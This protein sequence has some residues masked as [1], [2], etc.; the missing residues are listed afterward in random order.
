MV[1]GVRRIVAGAAEAGDARLV[2]R[3]VQS[4]Y[5]GDV[6]RNAVEP[7]LAACDG[8]ARGGEDILAFEIG[9]RIVGL[10]D[11][12][13]EGC[14]GR[15]ETERIVY[16]DKKAA[17]IRRQRGRTSGS[18]VGVE[19]AGIAA[20]DLG[21]KHAGALRRIGARGR[22]VGRCAPLERDDLLLLRSTWSC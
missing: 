16:P 10:E 5:P 11:H 1:A 22:V 4:A 14:A 21:G 2:E 17:D 13:A 15:V 3:I 9:P 20:G 6:D 8:A 7:L 12:R 18:A 19:I